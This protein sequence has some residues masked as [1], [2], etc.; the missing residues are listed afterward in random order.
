MIRGERKEAEHEKEYLTDALARESE[1][2]IS[3][4]KAQ[5][6]VLTVCFNAPHSPYEADP[7]CLKRFSSM[8]GEKRVYASMIAS[9]D[10]AIGRILA[11]LDEEGLAQKTLVFF[12]SDNGA[13]TEEGQGT[14]GEFRQGKAFLFEG[15]SRVP[16]V[17]RWPAHGTAGARISTPVSLLDVTAT[18]L[19]L[20]GASS[21]ALAELDGVDLGPLLA[22][23][24]QPERPFF[25]KLGPSAAIRKGAW[26]L[27]TS[28]SSRW[29]FNLE[30]DPTESSDLVQ[31][32]PEVV[33]SLSKELA[34]WVETLPKP[35]WKND[36]FGTPIKVLGKPYW[37]EF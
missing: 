9:M 19:K 8:K 13:P 12:S 3:R 22:G 18:T 7:S 31:Q 17:A 26:K 28:N 5:P 32:K 24:P 25:W 1:A 33:E 36:E 21:E 20:A 16:L 30:R 34:A 27:V 23:E 10:D 4:N 15:G 35:L 14:N 37:I 6:F 2:F 29:L 11:K